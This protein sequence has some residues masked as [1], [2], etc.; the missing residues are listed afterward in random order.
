[1]SRDYD[2]AIIVPVRNT[3]LRLL[4]RC[5]ESLHDAVR[6]SDEYRARIIV[7]D[8]YSD[9]KYFETYS[10]HIESIF[11]DIMIERCE[12][13][14]GIGGARNRGADL[15]NSAYLLFVDSD[16]VL[17]SEAVVT[18][19]RY[20]HE[21]GIVFAD[22][23]EIK[24]N[25]VTKY[26][27]QI[28]LEILKGLRSTLESPFL[29]TNFICMPALIP[30]KL[31]FQAG[32][33]PEGVYSGEH[34]ALWGKLYFQSDLEVIT[35]VGEVLYEY[36]PRTDGN[37]HRD[38]KRHVIGKCT[39]FEILATSV[40]LPVVRYVFL[41]VGR[42]MPSLYVPILQN[43]GTYVPSWAKRT[44]DSWEVSRQFM[45]AHRGR[46]ADPPH[47]VYAV[48]CISESLS[49]CSWSRD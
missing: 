5:L 40:G 11:P 3:P 17:R 13:W 14:R 6:R 8:D 37:S 38:L 18:L 24:D 33:Y 39:Q 28:F 45:T 35:F 34:V 47:S 19:M 7:V 26:D 36:Y 42:N 27:R 30:R 16:D 29:Y 2:L 22:N 49:S 44:G 20:A 9:N 48:G 4:E 15:S 41:A 21:R 25:V 31:F 12:T 32:G 10:H 23:I 43:V 46:E 1:M